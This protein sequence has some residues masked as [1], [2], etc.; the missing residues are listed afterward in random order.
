MQLHS[1]VDSTDA[2]L[3]PDEGATKLRGRLGSAA[4]NHSGPARRDD[5]HVHVGPH[6]GPYLPTFFTEIVA[7]CPPR[8]TS[9]GVTP[10]IG[11]KHSRLASVSPEM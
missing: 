7:L 1:L 10:A 2:Y 9:I 6:S 3:S 5:G 8:S 11:S 4:R